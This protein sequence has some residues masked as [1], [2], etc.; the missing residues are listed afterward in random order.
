VNAQYIQKKLWEI[1]LETL[2]ALL[3]GHQ[4]HAGKNPKNLG[5]L[6]LGIV[7]IVFRDI[8]IHGVKI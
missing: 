7:P 3:K 1:L 6:L 4:K 8:S 5:G 2:E